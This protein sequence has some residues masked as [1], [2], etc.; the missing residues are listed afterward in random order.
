LVR[1]TCI[2]DYSALR[3][4]WHEVLLSASTLTPSSHLQL[5]FHA[6]SC[7]SGKI[8]GETPDFENN[9]NYGLHRLIYIKHSVCFQL[10]LLWRQRVCFNWLWCVHVLAVF[11]HLDKF[12]FH[13]QRLFPLAINPLPLKKELKTEEW[14][15]IVVSQILTFQ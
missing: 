6:L 11:C 5:S 14:K 7:L 12:L 15:K 13:K 10:M 9:Q 3:F 2:E 4:S 1:D 8:A